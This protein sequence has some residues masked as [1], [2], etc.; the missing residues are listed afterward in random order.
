[1]DRIR[2]AVEA[3]LDMEPGIERDALLDRVVGDNVRSTV[4]RL[5]ADSPLL[6]DRIERGL[7]SIVG[8]EYSLHDGTVDFF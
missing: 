3:R 2:P 1:V 4:K 5:L 7:L 6:T 8:A